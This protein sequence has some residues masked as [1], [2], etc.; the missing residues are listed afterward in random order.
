MSKIRTSIVNGYKVIMETFIYT[1][2]VIILGLILGGTFIFIGIQMYKLIKKRKK[3]REDFCDGLNR[4]AIYS[5]E[6]D[7]ECGE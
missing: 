6:F 1:L 5:K 4:K 2:F 7:N 3:E